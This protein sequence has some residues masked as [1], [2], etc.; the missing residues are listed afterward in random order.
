MRRSKSNRSRRSLRRRSNRPTIL[1]WLFV[2]RSG[3]AS[4]IAV[5]LLGAGLVAAVVL[6]RRSAQSLPA[7]APPPAPA[8]TGQP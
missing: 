5:L 7:P 6:L 3:R 4:R 2:A 1:N 8:S